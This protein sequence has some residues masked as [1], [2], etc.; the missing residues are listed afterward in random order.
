LPERRADGYDQA[1]LAS[2]LPKAARFFPAARPSRRE[3]ALIRLSDMGVARCAALAICLWTLDAGAFAQE[4]SVATSSPKVE[5]AKKSQ[6]KARTTPVEEK[7]KSEAPASAS[8]PTPPSVNATDGGPAV[9]APSRPV[10]EEKAG[11]APLAT[12]PRPDTATPPPR[13]PDASREKMRACAIEWS[14]LKL[15]AR[16][17]MPLWRDF[18]SKCLTR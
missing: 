17:P 5:G 15:E 12:L 9:R 14:K 4:T 16:N 8:R 2:R 3:P 1:M 13:L 6:K 18:G 10:R 11:K 7:A